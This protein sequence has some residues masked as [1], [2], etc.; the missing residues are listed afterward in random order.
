MNSKKL[1]HNALVALAVLFWCSNLNAQMFNG[2]TVNT[3]GNSLIPSTGTG[4]CTVAPQ[5]GPQA[6]VGPPF[7]DQAQGGPG[8]PLDT[9]CQTAVCAIDG[10][11]CSVLWDGICAGE[12]LTFPQ[13]CNCLQAPNC[14]EG[15]T[16]FNATV[17]GLAGN[18]IVDQVQV[19]FTHTWDSDLA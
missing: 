9:D 11:C 14:P 8:Y 13:C 12:A 5:L 4:G 2:N 1:T 19:N 6:P 17:G 15:G 10:F 18:A 16:N 7:C 3:A